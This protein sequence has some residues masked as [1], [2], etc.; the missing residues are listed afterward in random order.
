MILL[1]RVCHGLGETEQGGKQTFVDMLSYRHL[2]S[3]KLTLS[4]ED[5]WQG[6]EG[7]TRLYHVPITE[8]DILRVSLSPKSK[9][10][11]ITLPGPHTFVVTEG[12]VKASVGDESFTLKNGHSAFVRANAELKL[13]LVDGEKGEVYG[14]FFQ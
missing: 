13:E 3:S 5:G 10:E 12:T 11:S 6:K 8:F 2:P 4:Y 7:N 9:T 14:S 1:R